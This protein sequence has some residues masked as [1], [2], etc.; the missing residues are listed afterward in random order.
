MLTQAQVGYFNAFG[1]LILR[2]VLSVEEVH[3]LNAEFDA[4]LATTTDAK[5]KAE[6]SLSMSWPN[7]GPDTPFTGSLLED[8]RIIE[9]VDSIYTDG[10]YGISCNASSKSGDTAWHPDSNFR[11]MHGIKVVTYLQPLNGNNGALRVIPGSHSYPLHDDIKQIEVRKPK[12]DGLE[13]DTKVTNADSDSD[14]GFDICEV[15]AFICS[16]NP[17][18]II[19]FDFRVW[20]AS[21]GGSNDRR[22]LS[23]IFIKQAVSPEE[24]EAINEQVLLS[25]KVR[26][27]RAKETFDKLRPEYHPDWIANRDN[28]PRRQRWIDWM[29]EKRY[30]EALA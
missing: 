3:K 13:R 4:K 28:R 8:S 20:H 27:A 30:F 15:P 11:R 25:R 21:T 18:D 5:S 9:I 24:D 19:V 2:N 7:L 16:V 12:H 22:M 10:F 23:M 1:V 17:G 6:K 14:T 26:A 29:R